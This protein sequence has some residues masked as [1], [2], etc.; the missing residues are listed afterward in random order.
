[1]K[2][3]QREGLLLQELS[4]ENYFFVRNFVVL[5]YF[6]LLFF[7]GFGLL[8]YLYSSFFHYILQGTSG[9]PAPLIPLV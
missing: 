8:L 7:Y 3:R 9:S 5:K 2:E 4:L 1:M 6:L